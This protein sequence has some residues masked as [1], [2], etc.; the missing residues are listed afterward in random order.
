[1]NTTVCK[2]PPHVT[3]ITA[4]SLSGNHKSQENNSSHAFSA[5]YIFHWIGGCWRWPTVWSKV[6]PVSFRTTQLLSKQIASFSW[7]EANKKS[8]R[9]SSLR[10]TKYHSH[11]RYRDKISV[12]SIL[13]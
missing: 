5:Q 6:S 11:D 1:M 12:V 10:F 7:T 4:E 8:N 13:L 2:A 9:F 3:T